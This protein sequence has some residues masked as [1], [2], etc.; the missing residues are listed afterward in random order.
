MKYLLIILLIISGC[1]ENKEQEKITEL[2]NI[3][4]SIEK[5]DFSI[6]DNYFSKNEL[7]PIFFL[8]DTVFTNINHT[9]I[10][11][12]VITFSNNGVPLV[13]S[14][15]YGMIFYE[16][17]QPLVSLQEISNISEQV[18]PLWSYI[19]DSKTNYVKID[20]LA[21]AY[22]SVYN[23][24]QNI[25]IDSQLRNSIVTFNTP[26][27]YAFDRL[28]SL[29]SYF[30]DPANRND[31]KNGKLLRELGNQLDYKLRIE[32][33]K[34]FNQ[35]L[36]KKVTGETFDEYRSTLANAYIKK[37][38]P[39]NVQNTNGTLEVIMNSPVSYP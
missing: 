5:Q 16:N 7:Y 20:E 37:L 24:D 28:M 13:Y 6:F 10:H 39:Q 2:Q 18:C 27:A 12:K 38:Y 31:S 14:N 25:N 21:D 9:N 3:I 26:R 29:V 15:Q 8:Q 35:Y 22:T 33:E 30:E 36:L 34:S 11:T 32:F 1:T 4:S 23:L 19:T 17:S